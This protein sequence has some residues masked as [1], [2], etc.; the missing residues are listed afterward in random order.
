MHIMGSNTRYNF[1]NTYFT[2]GRLISGYC[3]I[4]TENIINDLPNSLLN[5]Y[6]HYITSCFYHYV[7]Y[8]YDLQKCLK[9]LPVLNMFMLTKFKQGTYKA[10]GSKWQSSNMQQNGD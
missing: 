10:S 1:I 3:L 7:S 5:Q 9:C 4:N 6:L 8:V 2:V